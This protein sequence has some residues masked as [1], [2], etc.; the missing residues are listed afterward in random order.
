MINGDDLQRWSREVAEDP[1]APTFVPLARAYRR[2]GRRDA[3]RQVLLHGLER[4]PDH[5][6]AHAL[7]AL[8]HVEDGRRQRA[9]DE[10]EIVLRLDPKNFEAS[11]GLG[12]LALERGDLVGSRRHLEAAA[13][14]RPTDPAV[15]QALQVLRRREEKARRGPRRTTNGRREPAGLFSALNRDAPFLGALLVDARGLVLA[16]SLHAAAATGDALGGLLS[17]AVDE[18]RRTT[19]ILGLGDW[20]S[21]LVD[22]EGA[23][24]HV[25]PLDDSL[26]VLAAR[27]NAPAG[28]VVSAARYAR[29]LAQQFLEE[30]P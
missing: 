25:A 8:I 9:G 20:N 27:E 29:E 11:R 5:V 28:W 14:A 7:L 10:W 19:E 16:G 12:F 30:Q 26:V 24:L 23:L 4:N 2:Q 3:A 22:C 18:A 21:M 6:E 13:A 17:P 1:G 15:Q